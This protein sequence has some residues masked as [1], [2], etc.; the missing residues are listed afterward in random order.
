MR[1]IFCS[2][3]PIYVEYLRLRPKIFLVLFKNSPREAP[4]YVSWRTKRIPQDSFAFSL[5][6]LEY[7]L[8]ILGIYNIA[9][10]GWQSTFVT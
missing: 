4:F 1:W 3:D 2:F 6:E 8:H 7:F 5:Y 9:K 10:Y